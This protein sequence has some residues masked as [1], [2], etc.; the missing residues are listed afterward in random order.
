VAKLLLLHHT[1]NAGWPQG[2]DVWLAPP[3][4]N[5]YLTVRFPHVAGSQSACA[6]SWKLSK[7]ATSGMSNSRVGGIF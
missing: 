4:Q 1:W 6:V 5:G 7:E 3:S 2:D